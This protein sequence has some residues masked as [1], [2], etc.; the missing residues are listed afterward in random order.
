MF[1]SSG[2][3]AGA[4]L[5]SRLS[6]SIPDGGAGSSGHGAPLSIEREPTALDL[7]TPS[8]D[9]LGFDLTALLAGTPAGQHANG[10]GHQGAGRQSHNGISDSIF[11][12]AG[13]AWGMHCARLALASTQQGGFHPG[14]TERWALILG[15]CEMP[16]AGGLADLDQLI[17]PLLANMG[18]HRRNQHADGEHDGGM[19][20]EVC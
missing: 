15:A 18:E 14:V 9:A 8:F 2:L 1:V 7:Q 17:S 3:F 19:Q 16:P 11:S 5:A 10:A 20:A 4:A 6:V 12:P 13:G